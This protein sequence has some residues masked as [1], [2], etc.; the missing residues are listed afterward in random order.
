MSRYYGPYKTPKT[1]CSGWRWFSVWT[2]LEACQNDRYPPHRLTRCL[3]RDMRCIW[4][5]I[6]SQDITMTPNPL[7]FQLNLSFFVWFFYTWFA[8]L[9]STRH[10]W[11][12]FIF[13]DFFSATFCQNVDR[14]FLEITIIFPPPWTKKKSHRQSFRFT[15][16]SLHNFSHRKSQDWVGKTPAST[17]SQLEV[18]AI[19]VRNGMSWIVIFC[20]AQMSRIVT[21]FFF[22]RNGPKGHYYRRAFFLICDFFLEIGVLSQFVKILTAPEKSW[23]VS[24][25]DLGNPF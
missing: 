24:I 7:I 9:S 19:F 6:Q 13:Y 2:F 10:L 20:H 22:V 17:W 16:A 15:Q 1:L 3:S 5:A 11:H 25:H 18:S 21:F 23:S 12:L 8:S 4:S 14:V